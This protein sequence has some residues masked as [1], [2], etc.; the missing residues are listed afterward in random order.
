MNETPVLLPCFVGYVTLPYSITTESAEFPRRTIT[1][2][3]LHWVHNTRSYRDWY[4]MVYKICMYL[5]S[6]NYPNQ[7]RVIR[8]LHTR[9][10]I[11]SDKKAVEKN[12]WRGNGDTVPRDDELEDRV[13]VGLQRWS[14]EGKCTARLQEQGLKNT[15]NTWLV[16]L[17]GPALLICMSMNNFRYQQVDSMYDMQYR[18]K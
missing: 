7:W 13:S 16:L 2:R 1:Q 3:V 4:I 9:P 8:D 5:Y 18:F 10:I 14:K 17:L 6:K 11:M 15:R 12:N